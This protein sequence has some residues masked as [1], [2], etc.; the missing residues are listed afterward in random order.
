MTA[1]MRVFHIATRG[2]VEQLRAEGILEPDSLATQGFVHCSTELQVVPTTACYFAPDADLVLIE[3]AT[4]AAGRSLR[5][6]EVSLA[7]V[8]A[9]HPTEASFGASVRPVFRA[10]QPLVAGVVEAG[11]KPAVVHLAAI[12][13]APVRD[14]GELHVPDHRQ[15]PFEPPQ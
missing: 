5:R 14:A 11:E 7:P 4:D 15:R 8:E 6:A 3:I 1:S 10:D 12:R 2:A 13:F 9:A